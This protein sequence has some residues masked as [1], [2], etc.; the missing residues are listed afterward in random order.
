MSSLE[1]KFQPVEDKH[2]CIYPLSLVE[3]PKL[4]WLE[5]NALLNFGHKNKMRIKF[6]N[7]K[8]NFCKTALE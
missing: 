4:I 8:S 3:Y 5:D 7:K 1:T 2:I 6:M